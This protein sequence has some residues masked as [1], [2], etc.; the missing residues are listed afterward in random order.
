MPP[1]RERNLPHP[2][3][4]V[5]PGTPPVTRPADVAT[6]G[7]LRRLLLR[8]WQ[9]QSIATPTELAELRRALLGLER[10]GEELDG[11]LLGMACAQC[12]R[13][14]DGKPVALICGFAAARLE[15]CGG[16]AVV[17]MA[18]AA[19][20]LGCSEPSFLRALMVFLSSSSSFTSGRDVAAASKVLLQ[21]MREKNL[22]LDHEGALRGLAEVAKSFF[23]VDSGQATSPVVRDATEFMHSAAQVA[24]HG[25]LSLNRPEIETIEEA[26]SCVLSF[27]RRNLHLA[28]AR[29][30]AMVAGTLSTLWQVTPQLRE[31]FLWPCLEDVAQGV[32]FKSHDFNCQDLA[33]VAQAFAKL[34]RPNEVFANVLDRCFCAARAADRDLCYLLWAAATVPNWANNPFVS[35]VIHEL[36]ARDPSRVSS[37]DLCALLQSLVKL[38]H[39]RP[40]ARV[41]L[42]GLYAE[43]LRRSNTFSAKD[44][45]CL[46]RAKE[47]LEDDTVGGCGPCGVAQ[48]FFP[49]PGIE[50]PVFQEMHGRHAHGH[51]TQI[52][53]HYQSYHGGHDDHACCHSDGHGQHGH[54]DGHSHCIRGVTTANFGHGHDEAH[55]YPRDCG[56]GMERI[57]GRPANSD[58]GARQMAQAGEHE[59]AEREENAGSC[60]NKTCCPMIGDGPEMQ[61]NS[62]CSFAG[63]CVRM[64]NTFIH[65]PCSSF[66]D[67]ESEGECAVCSFKRSRSCDDLL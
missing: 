14:G 33:L 65:I 36:N 28:S 43:G 25:D 21:S 11:A 64:K 23:T 37:K 30:C 35:S 55:G 41:L 31:E 63:H 39:L 57:P 3:G 40:M 16:R 20:Q 49:P 24:G 26:F 45:S 4:R 13:L 12:A 56:T 9:S 19:L 10:S 61:L 48:G 17:E 29:D 47:A 7:T 51:E 15:M 32:R 44:L 62:H 6:P 52:E 38:L 67:S 34:E 27:L 5:A 60:Q 18:Q 8:L 58:L 66:S 1:R 53:G 54:H 59:H 50:V 22:C 46:E 42:Q 2:V